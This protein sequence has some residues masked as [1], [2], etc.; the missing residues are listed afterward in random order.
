MISRVGYSDAARGVQAATSRASRE[1][2]ESDVS[3]L[4][5]FVHG[6]SIDVQRAGDLDPANTELIHEILNDEQSMKTFL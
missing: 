6:D 1:M 3:S 4:H 5:E 2:D